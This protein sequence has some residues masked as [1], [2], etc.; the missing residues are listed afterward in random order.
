MSLHHIR[1]FHSSEPNRSDD[2]RIGFAIRYI[3]ARIRQLEVQ[4][5]SATLVRG[6]DRHGHFELERAPRCDFGREEVDYHRAI[7]RRRH[8]IYGKA[9]A[10]ADAKLA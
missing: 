3:P 8:G 2:R 1:T 7:T 9:S 10:A 4:G 6:T 5:D